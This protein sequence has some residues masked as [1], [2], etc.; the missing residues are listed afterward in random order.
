MRA[1]SLGVGKGSGEGTTARPIPSIH[2]RGCGNSLPHPCVGEPQQVWGS[3]AE[4]TE[5]N[6]PGT[7]PGRGSSMATGQPQNQVPRTYSSLLSWDRGMERKGSLTRERHLCALVGCESWSPS[8]GNT[9]SWAARALASLHPGA[10]S[11]TPLA[12]S[13]SYHMILYISCLCFPQVDG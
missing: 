3:M 2:W 5:E 10:G 6:S 1:V 9:D 12:S 13:H 7:S 8:G 4:I 11:P